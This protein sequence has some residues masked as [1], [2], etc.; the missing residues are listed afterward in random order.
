MKNS[1]QEIRCP[2]YAG[3]LPWS[4][5]YD[6]GHEHDASLQEDAMLEFQ[7]KQCLILKEFC[8]FAAR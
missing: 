7:R 3:F 5:P 8:D 1:G 6:E 4:L 2:L